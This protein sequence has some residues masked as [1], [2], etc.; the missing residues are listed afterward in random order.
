MNEISVVTWDIR[1]T[2]GQTCM[3]V[4]CR[5]T[6]NVLE[7]AKGEGMIVIFVRSRKDGCR[8]NL[9]QQHHGIEMSGVVSVPGHHQW[10]RFLH[11]EY[12]ATRVTA[13]KPHTPPRLLHPLSSAVQ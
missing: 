5:Q 11:A 12:S 2:L 8:A 13:G 3:E 6:E 10:R 4:G 1:A 9:R 7:Q